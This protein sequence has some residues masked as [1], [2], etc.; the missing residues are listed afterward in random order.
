MINKESLKKYALQT[1][2]KV[3]SFLSNEYLESDSVIKINDMEWYSFETDKG[4]VYIERSNSYSNPE[5]GK[6]AKIEGDFA[7]SGKFKFGILKYVTIENGII[8]KITKS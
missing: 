4:I 6:K 1:L 7:P 3:F 8:V 5:I 2:E